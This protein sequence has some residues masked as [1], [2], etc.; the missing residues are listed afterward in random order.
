MHL[1]TK[2]FMKLLIELITNSMIKNTM[3]LTLQ[4]LNNLCFFILS[5]K[6]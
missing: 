5:L 1:Y 2:Y 4:S 3:H 6:A